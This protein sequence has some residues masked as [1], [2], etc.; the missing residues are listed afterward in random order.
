MRVCVAIVIDK[1]EILVS[2]IFTYLIFFHSIR[3]MENKKPAS[4]H[5]LGVLPVP[6]KLKCIRVE[7]LIFKTSFHI[8]RPGRKHFIWSELV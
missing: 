1:S 5:H 7:A 2:R 8:Y 6:V 4:D 3:W